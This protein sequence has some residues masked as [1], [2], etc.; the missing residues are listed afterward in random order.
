[1]SL[2]I[3]AKGPVRGARKP[4]LI[5]ADCAGAVGGTAS[6]AA[7]VSR[8]ANA[9][10]RR[11]LMAWSPSELA[12]RRP[13]SAQ[14]AAGREQT[15]ADVDGAQD[16]QASL[17]VHADEILQE[18][19]GGGAERRAGKRPGPAERDHQQRLDGRHQLTVHGADE[20]VVP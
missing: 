20:A 1:M 5:G 3:W 2:P 9:T 7:K 4:I 19:D 16:Q 6:G 10:R 12:F 13:R 11:R 14:D 18:D 17:G 15:D 8:T